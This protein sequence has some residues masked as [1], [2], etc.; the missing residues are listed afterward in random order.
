MTY[1]SFTKGAVLFNLHAMDLINQLESLMTH[2]EK[3]KTLLWQQMRVVEIVSAVIAERIMSN[4][5][6]INLE[7]EEIFWSD[8]T[9]SK[10]AP[11]P[12]ARGRKKKKPDPMGRNGIYAVI[13][14]TYGP[15]GKGIQK[16]DSN[17]V[18]QPADQPQ[19]TTSSVQKTTPR[20]GKTG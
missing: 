13:V 9:V 20:K 14:N 11:S 4:G 1:I 6:T 10:A 19:V 7:P 2:M 12:K 5:C 16:S 15:R 3:N 17:V 18:V 8:G